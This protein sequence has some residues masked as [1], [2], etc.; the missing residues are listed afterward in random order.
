MLRKLTNTCFTCVILV[1]LM[2]GKP[3]AA[4]ILL[5]AVYNLSGSQSAFDQPSFRGARL[6]VEQANA[7]GG[8]LGQQVELVLADPASSLAGATEKTRQLVEAHGSMSAVLGFSDSDMVLAAAPVVAAR[9]LVFMT[10]GATS[11]KLTTQV[12]DY[13]FLACFG[14]NV[15]A[16]AA[17]EYAYHD[18]AARTVAILYNAAKTY[19]TLLQGYFRTRFE[20]LGGKVVA[21]ESYETTADQPR[22]LAGLAKADLVFLSAEAP[23]EAAAGATKLRQA[24]IDVPILGGDG[25]DVEGEWAKHPALRE[26]YF[27]THA[28]LAPDN[29]DSVVRAFDAAYRRAYGGGAPD[30]FAALGYDAVGV[31]LAAV[32][33]GRS[34]EP[35]RVLASLSH[36]QG[37]RGVTGTISYAGGHR[38]PRKSV[39]ILAVRGGKL[40]FVKQAVPVRVPAP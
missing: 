19:T 22:A 13:L 23:A 20:E 1:T 33:A 29:P 36:L 12:P 11:P 6:A 30:S 31:L 24:G 40:T 7:R 8:I 28:Y 21:V 39:T 3:A 10:S 37:Y 17:A 2:S 27:T 25:F 16:A 9:Q 4:R 34:A 15:Q 14:D 26:V 38:I 35:A 32:E 18:L 5:G